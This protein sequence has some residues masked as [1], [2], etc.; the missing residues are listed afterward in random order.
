ML[1]AESQSG[2]VSWP[3][4]NPA[5]N[6]KKPPV[7]EALC[8]LFFEPRDWDDTVPG[9]FYGRMQDEFTIKEQLS[10]SETEINMGPGQATTVGVRPLPPRM[11]FFTPT[12][13]RLIQLGPNLLVVNKL[14]PYTS[15]EDWVGTLEQ[16]LTHYQEV[17]PG[18]AVTRVGVRYLNRIAVPGDRVELQNY[19]RVIPVLP[20]SLGK[21]HGAFLLRLEL[22]VPE[23]DH[24]LLLSF[25]TS[26]QEQLGKMTFLLDFH[27]TWKPGSPQPVDQ[28]IAH[29]RLA[30]DHIQAAFERNITDELRLLFQ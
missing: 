12:R 18:A 16:A 10:G 1:A 20:E 14:Q 28:V 30:H 9:A 27:E 23:K 6:Y 25:A 15:F 17:V 19:F 8:E 24:S 13:D 22:L 5:P 21:D 3:Q 26:P 11:R 7:V 4:M 29:V 2:T